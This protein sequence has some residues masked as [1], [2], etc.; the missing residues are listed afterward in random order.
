[1]SLI[2]KECTLGPNYIG[3]TYEGSSFWKTC[4]CTY[5]CSDTKTSAP[6]HDVTV[7]GD[8]LCTWYKTEV[9]ND[10]ECTYYFLN[11]ATITRK[12]KAGPR[13]L[14][15]WCCEECNYFLGNACGDPDLYYIS[16]TYNDKCDKGNDCD[17]P[18][19]S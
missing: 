18:G 5:E 19:K 17:K 14:L 4:E 6:H 16:S 10:W 15:T 12:G 13:Y 1:M 11:C 7:K 9:F 3:E 2:S 8:R